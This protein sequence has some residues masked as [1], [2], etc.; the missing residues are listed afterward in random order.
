[1]TMIVTIGA[2]VGKEKLREVRKAIAESNRKK[3]KK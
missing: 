3:R 1:M 2:L